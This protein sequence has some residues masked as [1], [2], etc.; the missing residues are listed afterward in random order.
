MGRRVGN[1]MKMPVDEVRYAEE[2]ETCP[3]CHSNLLAVRGKYVVCSLCEIKGRIELKEDALRVSYDQK[4][5]QKSRWG[6]WGT[7][8][9]YEEIRRGYRIYKENK[10]EISKRM[11][12]YQAYKTCAVPP[13]LESW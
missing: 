8:K 1:A 4:E 5:L 6:E 3:L 9:H 7:K 10:A 11:E 12:K 13:P 2:F